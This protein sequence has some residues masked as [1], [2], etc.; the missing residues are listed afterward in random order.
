[1]ARQIPGVIDCESI[2]VADNHSSEASKFLQLA[3]GVHGQCGSNVHSGDRASWRLVQHRLHLADQ[4]FLNR[5]DA[6][7]RGL[8]MKMLNLHRGVHQAANVAS[9][10]RDDK[11]EGETLQLLRPFTLPSE[12]TF[13]KMIFDVC[14]ER[15]ELDLYQ[16]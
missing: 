14:V 6:V 1:M 3:S 2:G 13:S 4:V 10:V 12:N 8:T 16:R 9:T 5:H 7:S 11:H 15:L